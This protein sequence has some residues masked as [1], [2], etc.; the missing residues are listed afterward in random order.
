[1]PLFSGAATRGR[2]WRTCR[3]IERGGYPYYFLVT[4]TG[5]PRLLEPTVPRVDEAGAFFKDLAGR[6]GRR[7]VI[8]RYDPVIFPSR[9][10]SFSCQELFQVGR[11]AGPV[12]VPGDR[13]FLR[14]LCQGL[15]PIAQGGDRRRGGR[16]QPGTAAGPAGALSPPSLQ[17]QGWKFK[18]AP[19]PRSQPVSRPGKCI[20]EKLLNELFG[21]NL[22]YRKDPAQRKL[23]LCQQSVDIGCYG[24]CG[25][26][27][28]YCY[29]RR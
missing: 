16:R 15:A 28:L 12:H 11:P 23:C 4:L 27:C 7:R 21:L 22:S 8:W 29:A 13:Q 17:V 19:R 2:S 9:P 10:L 18:A 5:Y 6:I 3:K 26:G 1:M 14:P 24:T 20:D 25:H